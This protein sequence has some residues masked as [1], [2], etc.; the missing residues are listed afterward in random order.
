M[1]FSSGT[2]PL[3]LAVR[4]KIGVGVSNLQQVY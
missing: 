4:D 2:T 3:R 1:R